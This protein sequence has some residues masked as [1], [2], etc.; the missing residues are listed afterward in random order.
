M[1]IVF[2][3][4]YT[5]Y[6]TVATK[7]EI[8]VALVALG[9]SRESVEATFKEARVT[10]KAGFGSYVPELHAALLTNLRTDLASEHRVAQTIHACA[11]HGERFL[12]PGT[13]ELLERVRA[14]GYHLALLTLG[15]DRWQRAKATGAGLDRFFER[16]VTTLEDKEHVIRSFKGADERTIVVNDNVPEMIRMRD[17][18]PEFTYLIKRGPKGIPDECDFP[19]AE[20]MED[21]ARLI[22]A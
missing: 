3:L 13:I 8:I 20:T 22:L 12:Y 17:V 14:E 9:F 1:T 2:D 18:A 7:E 15:D 11:E 4:D 5:L 10:S 6:D 19:I 21:L 16:V